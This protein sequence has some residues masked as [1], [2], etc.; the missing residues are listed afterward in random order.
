[1]NK[2]GFGHLKNQVIYHENLRKCRFWGPM[3]IIIHQPTLWFFPARMVRSLDYFA[4]KH[5]YRFI[6]SHP[7]GFQFFLW[8]T[9]FFAIPKQNWHS[10]CGVCLWVCVCVGVW[11][12]VVVSLSISFRSMSK[13]H[14]GLSQVSAKPK[15]NEAF[16]IAA[17]LGKNIRDVSFL[18]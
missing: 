15:K 1:M 12:C 4:L 7:S 18:P 16:S 5:V 8:H 14:G 17:S 3:V 10:L 11:V 2:K 6:E 13:V 9:V